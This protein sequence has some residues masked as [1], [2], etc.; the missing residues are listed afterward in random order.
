VVGKAV[1]QEDPPA[2]AVEEE[3]GAGAVHIISAGRSPDRA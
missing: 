2:A 3:G 1:E